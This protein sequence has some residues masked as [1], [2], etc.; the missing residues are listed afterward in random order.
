VEC[1][2]GN[3]MDFNKLLLWRRQLGK[4]LSFVVSDR[5]LRRVDWS[6]TLLRGKLRVHTFERFAM[7]LS[8]GIPSCL[9]ESIGIS[10]GKKRS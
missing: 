5:G 6:V 3:G 2:G 1:G 9:G 8:E 7:V 4:L 10:I